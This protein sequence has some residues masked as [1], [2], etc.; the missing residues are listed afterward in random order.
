ME[1]PIASQIAALQNLRGNPAMVYASM[2]SD[3]SVRILYECLRRWGQQEHLDLVLLTSGGQV[4]ATRQL[5]LLLREY[6]HRLTILVPY[7]ARSA[8]T[9]LCLSAN[10]LVLGPLAQLGPIDSNISA[11]GPS[12]PDAP[13][14]ISATD[15]YTFRQM[16]ED[17]F[18]ITREEDRLQ[19]LALLAQRIFPTTLSAFYR[20]DQQIRRIAYEL[21]KYQMPDGEADV[22][23]RIVD[24]LA[25]GQYGHDYIISRTEARDLGL[26]T[27]FASPDEEVLLWDIL[28]ACYGQIAEHPG[29]T[30]QEDT[31][32]LIASE[33]FFAR[34]VQ[35]WIDVP[36][37]KQGSSGL[38]GITQ[39]EKINS[40]RWEISI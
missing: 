7:R 12:P 9:L 11:V 17:W 23:K 30:E 2:I 4:M 10:E 22:M 31:I 36:V 25:S 27:H 16:A 14:M 15:I 37:W 19:V 33:G 5:A 13:S 39:P 29:Q 32:G 21:L 6:I 28:L 26:H 34:Q 35:G 38:G 8:G 3:E 24:Q 40:I 20:F 18:G 1:S